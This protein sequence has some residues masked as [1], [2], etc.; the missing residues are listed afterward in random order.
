MK[1]QFCFYFLIEFGHCLV[2]C[3]VKHNPDITLSEPVE[4]LYLILNFVKQTEPSHFF[5]VQFYYLCW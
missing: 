2:K 5:W 1:K 3:L 4:Y